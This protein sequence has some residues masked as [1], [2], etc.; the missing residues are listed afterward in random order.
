MQC[1]QY[2]K[3]FLFA[4]AATRC[5]GVCCIVLPETNAFLFDSCFL[6]WHLVHASITKACLPEFT[7]L[8]S[9]LEQHSAQNSI[10]IILSKKNLQDEN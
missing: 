3:L 1:G 10:K 6:Y 5:L 9:I 7:F 4:F 8:G 2:A